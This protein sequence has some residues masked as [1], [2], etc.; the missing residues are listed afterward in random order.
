MQISLSKPDLVQFLEEQV[1]QGHFGSPEAVV[2]AALTL[3]QDAA[4]PPR[5]DP[6][7]LASI[8]TSQEQFELGQGRDLRDALG[9]LRLKY[10]TR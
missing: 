5:L 7:T 8:R 1:H 3:L 10:Q 6:E 2:E 9:Q 4:K